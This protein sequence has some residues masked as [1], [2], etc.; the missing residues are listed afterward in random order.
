MNEK[1]FLKPEAI[2]VNFVDD[3]IITNSVIGTIPLGSI[4]FDDEGE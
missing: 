4:P 2:I 3:D 1:T